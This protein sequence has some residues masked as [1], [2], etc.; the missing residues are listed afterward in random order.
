MTIVEWLDL[1]GIDFKMAS[2]AIP[3]FGMHVV[4]KSLY[5]CREGIDLRVVERLYFQQFL[6]TIL[7]PQGLFSLKSAKGNASY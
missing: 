5:D 2:S 7:L 3:F 4:A 6:D 1:K